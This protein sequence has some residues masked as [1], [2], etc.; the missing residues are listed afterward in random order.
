MKE[1][2]LMQISY[3]LTFATE[4]EELNNIVSNYKVFRF[5]LET[6]MKKEKRNELNDVEKQNLLAFLNDIRIRATK[7]FL[8]FETIKKTYKIE[9]D[10]KDEYEKLFSNED[11]EINDVF[12]FM[13]K[14]NDAYYMIYKE[15]IKLK[16][17]IAKI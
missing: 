12:E 8:K 16:E 9:I 10:I 17:K 6:V 11:I 15:V 1:E 13:K 14:L 5:N 4:V 7:L 2:E 3:L